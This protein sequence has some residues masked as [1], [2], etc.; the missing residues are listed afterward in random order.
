MSDT[1]LKERP[2]EERGGLR[3]TIASTIDLPR[4]PEELPGFDDDGPPPRP[5]RRGRRWL[6]WALVAVAVV[7]V[8]LP[9]LFISVLAGPFGGSGAPGGACA[10]TAGAQTLP[11]NL[12]APGQLGGIAG[13]GITQ[14][15]YDAV[16]R[17]PY[18]S[19]RISAGQYV[20]TAYG[21]PWGG[22]QG[23]GNQT[24]GGLRIDGG[25]PHKYFIAVDPKRIGHGTWVYVWPNP[26]GWAGPFLAADTGGAI[27]DGR[28]DFY[29]WRG[30]ATQYG[31]GRRVVQASPTPLGGAGAGDATP[32]AP[33]SG[34][35]PLG[36]CATAG[37]SGPLPLT[38]GE[39]AKI[40]PSGL[41]AAPM[42]AP[43]AIKRMIAAGNQIVGKPYL[44]GGGHGVP[45][46]RIS[47]TYD[48]SSS[49][50]HLLYGGGFADVDYT[51]A[52]GEMARSYGRPGWSKWV[53]MMANNGHVYM[54]VAGLRWDTHRWGSADQG[55]SGIGWH[56]AR[57][58]DTGFTPRHPEQLA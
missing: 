20:S 30:R 41:A 39:K 10:A 26:F 19:S 1:A 27:K 16:R 5:P 3:G 36:G 40:L 35:L 12:G 18:A 31:W 25:S 22:I 38:A 50:S 9:V 34:G 49:V 53:T 29:D 37:S 44:L 55:V 32:T 14:Q 7:V 58:P 15:D 51:P 13:T 52:S 46:T 42:D 56:S 54:Y 23:N 21:P 57:R 43:D 8:V 33:V 48:C 24:S 11:A 6:L 2:P 17:S 28:I 47:N 45:L 4:R